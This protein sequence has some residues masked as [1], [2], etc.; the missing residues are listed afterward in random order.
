MT[1]ERPDGLVKDDWNEGWME[2][3]GTGCRWGKHISWVLLRELACV[4]VSI[5]E[6]ISSG[7]VSVNLCTYCL[8]HKSSLNP[9][10]VK[11]ILHLLEI[12]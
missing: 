2:E 5:C 4:S 8:L 9:G 10:W 7:F 11:Y 6:F 3:N 12:T 1:S